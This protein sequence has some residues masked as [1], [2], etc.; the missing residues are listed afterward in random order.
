MKRR[1]YKRLDYSG[2]T[3]CDNAVGEILG[4][5]DS[6]EKEEAIEIVLD[7]DWKLK[8]LQD[9]ISKTRYKILDVKKE[10][11]KYIVTVGEE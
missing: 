1:I 2:V 6:L 4:Y 11:E 5:L 9:F 3:S 8:E 7:A 10:N